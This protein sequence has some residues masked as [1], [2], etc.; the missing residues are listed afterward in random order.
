VILC[1]LI[2]GL[3]VLC[4]AEVSSRFK[5][6]GGPYLYAYKAFGS[7]IGF[8]MGWLMWLTRISAF[9]AVC[10]LLVSYSVILWPALRSESIHILIILVIII[11]ITIVNLVGIKQSIIFNNLFVIS[12]LLALIIFVIIGFFFL[13]ADNLNTHHTPSINALSSGVLIMVFAF[14]GFELSTISAGEIKNP[15]KIFP[16]ALITSIIVITVFYISIQ[17][18]CMGTLPELGQ[19]DKPLADAASRFMGLPGA[20]LIAIGAIISM[21]GALNATFIACTRLPFAM[22]LNNQMPSLFS[23]IHPRYKTPHFSIILSSS[24]ILVFTFL[25]SFM[26]AVKIHVIIKLLT[27]ALVC[28]SLPIFRKRSVEYPAKYHLRWGGT[29]SFI[30]ILLCFWLLFNSSG[31]EIIHVTFAI[32]IGVFLYYLKKIL[33]Y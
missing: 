1:G 8:E 14:G 5:S 33:K 16:K 12:K 28:F 23:K 6:T 29:L 15:R 13:D 20:Y 24:L 32:I 10:N 9:A 19:S 21:I 30:S 7:F 2:I 17:V 3:I 27:Y 18:V 22:A 25:Y 26:E 31:I 4:F 11:F